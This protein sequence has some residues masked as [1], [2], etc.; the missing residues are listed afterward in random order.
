MMDLT[1]MFSERPGISGFRQQMP[2]ITSTISTPALLA[3]YSLSIRSG[4]VSEFIF[5]QIAAGLPLWALAISASIASLS[6]ERR[7]IGEIDSSS[8]RF[9]SM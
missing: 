7:L 1:T 8:V 5:A 6:V 4:S 3:S 9:G 2:R